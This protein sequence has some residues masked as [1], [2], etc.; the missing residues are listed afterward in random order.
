MK[1]LWLSEQGFCEIW[2]FFIDTILQHE[3]HFLKKDSASKT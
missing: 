3:L 2:R 1:V